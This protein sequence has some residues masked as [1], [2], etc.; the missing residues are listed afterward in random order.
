MP[1]ETGTHPD[2][3]IDELA[4]QHISPCEKTFFFTDPRVRKEVFMFK[5]D[6]WTSSAAKLRSTKFLA[7]MAIMIAMKVVI[8]AWY[9][10]VGENLRI[11][12][13]FFIT[14][15]E[16]C[17]LGPVAAAVSGGITDVLSFMIHP[18]GP[19]FFGYTLSSIAGSFIY[20]LLFYRTKVTLPRIIAAKALV[21]YLV[22]VLLGSLWSAMMFSKGYI[23]YATQSVIK[24]TLLLPLEIIALYAVFRI[25]L[26]ILQHRQMIRND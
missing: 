26:P 5:K 7:V 19:F 15:I 12:V 4:V 13:T 1:N 23:F 9:I 20:G 25:V 8:S 14:A 18:T 2:E 24:N 16:G 6:Y 21:N 3:K 17:I 22:N 10:P 11:H